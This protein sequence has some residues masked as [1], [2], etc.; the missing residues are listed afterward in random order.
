[1]SFGISIKNAN[2][3]IVADANFRNYSIF[4]TQTVNM[5][6]LPGAPY[7]R[8]LAITDRGVAPLV[9]VKMQRSYGYICTTAI[10]RTYVDFATYNSSKVGA[11]L[12][13][14]LMLAYPS[15]NPTVSGVQGLA[16]YDGAGQKTF[17][18]RWNMPRVVAICNGGALAT[19]GTVETTCFHGTGQSNPWFCLNTFSGVKGLLGNDNPSYL[20][21]QPAAAFDAN[22]LS[23]I[24]SVIQTIPQPLGWTQLTAAP[25]RS[26]ILS[27]P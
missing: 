21:V 22:N 9:F 19:N 2:G 24:S 26:V 5:S 25:F 10:S 11:L 13:F 1:M 20:L 27:N 7:G 14:P 8:R 16:I 12:S 17:D 23:Y 15:D 6:A 18:S 4:S 3:H